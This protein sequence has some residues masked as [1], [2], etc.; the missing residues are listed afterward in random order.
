MSG[1]TKLKSMGAIPHAGG[2][3]FRV[4]APNAQRVSVIGTFNDWDGSKHPMEA[5]DEGFW[6][7]D[8]SEAHIGDQYR[9]LLTTAKGEFKRIDPYAREVTSSIGNAIVH[10]PSFDWEGDDFHLPAR[11]ELVIYELHVGTFNDEADDNLPGQFASVSS[12]LGHLKKLG[13][14]A[15]QIM[16]IA[17]F[18][19]ERSWGYNPAHIFSVE[20]TYGGPLAFK[21]FVK[22]AHRYGIAVILDVVYNH[23]GPG[24]LDLWQFDGWSENERGG[25]YFYNDDRARTPWGETRPD[26]GRNEVRQYIF[27]NVFMWLD[28][29]H[30]DGLRFDGV[31]TFIPT[32]D[33]AA[34]TC[35]K[36]GACSNGSTARSPRNS[37]IGSRSPRTCRTTTGSPKTWEPAA[38]DSARSG[39]PNSFT[40]SARR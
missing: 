20:L 18:A 40:P 32:L 31:P 34:G 11:N 26:Y 14:N 5:E 36:A 2:V 9:Y 16:P 22:R 8:L 38:P 7:A 15:I 3:G 12:R 33:P 1:E 17:Q 23:F 19:G 24:D 39:M 10:D 35:P 37:P 30:V 21:K 25:I 28:E 29:Y 4:W 13:V 27:D 6:Y